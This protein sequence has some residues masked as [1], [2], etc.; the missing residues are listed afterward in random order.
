MKLSASP[1]RRARVGSKAWRNKIALSVRV[2][3]LGLGCALLLYVISLEIDRAFGFLSQLPSSPEP[4]PIAEIEHTQAAARASMVELPS[5][6]DAR[7]IA[8]FA[9]STRIVWL[10]KQQLASVVRKLE[11]QYAGLEKRYEADLIKQQASVADMQS[12]LRRLQDHQDAVATQVGRLKVERDLTAWPKKPERR[13][14][15]IPEADES[16]H[17]VDE[18]LG[19]ASAVGNNFALKAAAPR[20]WTS[21]TELPSQPSARFAALQ[22]ARKLDN[23]RREALRSKLERIFTI[24]VETRLLGEIPGS[25]LL[26]LDPALELRLVTASSEVID[27]RSG[28]IRFFPDGT[29]TGGRIQVQHDREGA[30]VDVDWSTGVVTVKVNGN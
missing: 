28:R 30:T 17:A 26:Q 5:D 6:G 23:A 13:G 8:H 22:I 24:D 2:A 25:K 14:R 21:N 16:G 3:P 27:E 12:E 11:T 19:A 15:L 4:L 29:S 20:L 9:T 7:A 10:E 18:Q 1:T